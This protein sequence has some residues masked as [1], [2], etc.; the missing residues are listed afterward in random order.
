[1]I[2]HEELSQVL[3]RD[4][5]SMAAGLAPVLAPTLGLRAEL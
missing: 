2:L 5:S 4:I 3:H 1:M